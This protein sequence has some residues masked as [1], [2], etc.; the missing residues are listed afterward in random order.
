MPWDHLQ[1]DIALD[2]AQLDLGRPDSDELSGFCFSR[3]TPQEVDPRVEKPRQAA[4]YQNNIHIL[5]AK[6]AA[7]RK[8]NRER[9]AAY[10]R[11]ARKR[12]R[13]AATQKL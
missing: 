9:L 11:E 8:A 13:L 2:F 4:Y 12:E 7:Y 5:K 6:Q 10:K 1:F 3:A